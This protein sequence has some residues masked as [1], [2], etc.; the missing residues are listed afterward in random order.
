VKFNWRNSIGE[1][2]PMHR[3]VAK[4]TEWRIDDE[5][6]QCDAT[7]R[8]AVFEFDQCRARS[9]VRARAGRTISRHPL[10]IAV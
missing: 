7:P 2:L 3:I 1:I 6:Q 4:L 10:F 5:Q 8:R 9:A